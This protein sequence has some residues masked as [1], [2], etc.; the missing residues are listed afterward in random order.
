MTGPFCKI[1]AQAMT[2]INGA[3]SMRA[4]IAPVKSIASLA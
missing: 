1:S 4:K 2:A 3:K